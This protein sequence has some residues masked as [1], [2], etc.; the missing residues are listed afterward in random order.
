MG[1]RDGARRGGPA[2]LPA[3]RAARGRLRVR[4]ALGAEAAAAEGGVM[5][6]EQSSEAAARAARG[7]VA[8][9]LQLIEQGATHRA[10]WRLIDAAGLL[11]F[12]A[13]DVIGVKESTGRGVR[14]IH[15]QREQKAAR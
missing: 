9:A 11:A 1:I 3:P 2:G 15:E 4:P 12:A 8:D 6:R 10:I 13:P 7:L 14:L 5:E